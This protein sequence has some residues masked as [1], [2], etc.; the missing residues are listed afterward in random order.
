[1]QSFD[2]ETYH[3]VNAYYIDMHSYLDLSIGPATKY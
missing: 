2:S 3:A 1:M